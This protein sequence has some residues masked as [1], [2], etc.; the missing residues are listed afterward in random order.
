MSA[1]ILL[2]DGEPDAQELHWQIFRCETRKGTI[3]FEFAQWGG[4]ALELLESE[5]V[6][7]S[8]LVLSDINMHGL[9]GIELPEK[10]WQQSPEIPLVMITACGDVSAKRTERDLGPAQFLTK[11]VDFAVLKE[12]FSNMIP[13]AL[14]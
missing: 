5:D 7:G 8:T 6:R 12:Q 2:V 9:T 1:H 10:I 4:E 13:Q 14:Q 11:P 3:T